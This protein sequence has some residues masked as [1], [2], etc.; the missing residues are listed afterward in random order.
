[1]AALEVFSFGV[2]VTLFF[3]GG[4]AFVHSGLQFK[5]AHVHCPSLVA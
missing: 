2:I 5:V 3:L 4:A 1:M